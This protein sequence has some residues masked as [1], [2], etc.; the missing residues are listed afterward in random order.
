[1]DRIYS[2]QLAK[3]AALDAA[4][5]NGDHEAAY[6]HAARAEAHL[7]VR[8]YIQ[9]ANDESDEEGSQAMESSQS[10]SDSDVGPPVVNNVSFERSADTVPVSQTLGILQDLLTH[11]AESEPLLDDEANEFSANDDDEDLF[12][13]LLDEP[14][15]NSSA[16]GVELEK[17]LPLLQ[18]Q[19]SQ[20]VS[21]RSQSSRPQFRSL[22]EVEAFADSQPAPSNLDT[23]ELPDQE[24][25][26][27][28]FDQPP[29]V[30]ELAAAR[31]RTLSLLEA[32]REHHDIKFIQDRKRREVAASLGSFDVQTVEPDE[33]SFVFPSQVGTQ[34]VRISSVDKAE[35]D[36]E[37]AHI[38]AAMQQ[39]PFLLSQLNAAVDISDSDSDVLDPHETDD[40][41]ESSFLLPQ[42]DGGGNHDDSAIQKELTVRAPFKRP[43][44]ATRTSIPAVSAPVSEK[45]APDAESNPTSASAPTI[46]ATLVA[47]HTLETTRLVP[48]Q[49][50][51]ANSDVKSVQRTADL[52]SPQTGKVVSAPFTSPIVLSNSVVESVS[53]I[54]TSDEDSESDMVDV[55]EVPPT[56]SPLLLPL[57]PFGEHKFVRVPDSSPPMQLSMSEELDHSE[58]IFVP[59]SGSPAVREVGLKIDSPLTLFSQDQPSVI[60]CSFSPVS[61]RSVP[62]V[63]KPAHPPP[64]AYECVSSLDVAYQAPFYS[65]PRH[66]HKPVSFAGRTVQI[67]GPPDDIRFLK[68]FE[69]LLDVDIKNGSS[70]A[71]GIASTRQL[72]DGVG[73]RVTRAVDVV[74]TDQNRFDDDES[75]RFAR[76]PCFVL[77]SRL[78]PPPPGPLWE[79][80]KRAASGKRRSA[81]MIEAAPVSVIDSA[82][83]QV[84]QSHMST[85][86]TDVLDIEAG[87]P[88]EL[89]LQSTSLHSQ[90]QNKVRFEVPAP[91][92]TAERKPQ[93]QP[94][95][96]KGSDM[97]LFSTS[98]SR[99]FQSA[100]AETSNNESKVRR[101]LELREG[102][103][104]YQNEEDKSESESEDTV[105]VES[106]VNE[107]DASQPIQSAP[108][109]ST[110]ASLPVQSS[111]L[112]PSH[113][114]NATWSSLPFCTFDMPPLLTPPQASC[115]SAPVI[116]SGSPNVQS[117]AV[118]SS[119]ESVNQPNSLDSSS[120]HSDGLQPRL[121][122]QKPILEAAS[123]SALVL[124]F[125]KFHVIFV[126]LD[127]VLFV[128][129]RN[130]LLVL[131]QEL[132][133]SISICE[134]FQ[135][136][137]CV[138][139][140][141]DCCPTHCT[142]L[143]RRLLIVC[144]MTMLG[145]VVTYFP[146]LN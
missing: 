108:D 138:P 93:E 1:M 33:R 54:D 132:T 136:K 142:I 30:R 11:C 42:F 63:L 16:D 17:V 134:C 44:L 121:G 53:F 51:V 139:V 88:A 127:D 26:F 87:T 28:V 37:E 86:I 41:N 31:S 100:G 62:A 122:P 3:L 76:R 89:S 95:S 119:S 22:E 102:W 90:S 19:Y 38:L 12:A 137:F 67:G 32:G 115:T 131:C 64:S 120:M 70:V 78:Q 46:T 105:A 80:A 48:V 21:Q 99:H 104:A 141:M 60:S 114:G 144:E 24:S 116:S 96:P 73:D 111:P 77:K 145:C 110:A 91:I 124:L 59:G 50:P 79:K 52:S 128:F 82:G 25:E 123:D 83:R 39:N 36:D 118:M 71:D 98:F 4:K 35:Q 61:S 18:S 45:A 133:I 6:R 68:P 135:S 23:I 5:R 130:P 47:D 109:P 143:F 94:D 146:S 13:D 8:V 15:H 29:T 56:P 43:R 49:S 103:S 125:T 9:P 97:A 117:P 113:S 34:S 10:D 101:Y 65:D 66:I 84:I 112:P 81:D 126:C 27:S 129:C 74:G 85:S 57:D 69:S 20:F 107:D 2:E 75:M 92:S 140:E 55:D 40:Q 106:A 14:L 58:D 7:P 72:V